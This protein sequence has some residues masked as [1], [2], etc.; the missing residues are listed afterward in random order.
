[1][2]VIRIANIIHPLLENTP[3]IGECSRITK[4]LTLNK[5]VARNV[6]TAPAEEPDNAP[7]IQIYQ[8]LNKI[9]L[10]RLVAYFI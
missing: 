2:A 3:M 5:Q 1:M 9:Q 4:S 8:K 10:T 7:N 6:E